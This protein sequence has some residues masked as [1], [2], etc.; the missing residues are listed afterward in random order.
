[1]DAGCCIAGEFF[2]SGEERLEHMHSST[3][4]TLKRLRGSLS[5]NCRLFEAET[6]YIR[7]KCKDHLSR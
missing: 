5:E 3:P 7:I 2:W 1:M 4:A 6:R